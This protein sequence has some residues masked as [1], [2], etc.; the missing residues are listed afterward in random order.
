M[1]AD[2]WTIMQKEWREYFARSGSRGRGLLAAILLMLFGAVLIPLQSG[3]AWL[4]SPVPTFIDG[5]YLPFIVVISVIAD[6][7]AGERERHTLESL[8]ATRLSDR[9]IL[10][11]KIGAAV[12]YALVVAFVS[13]LLGALI[14]D[15]VVLSEGKPLH[16]VFYSGGVVASIV[17]TAL[18]IAVLLAALGCLISLRSPT[19]RQAQQTLSI[20]VTAV[21]FILGFGAQFALAHSGVNLR[22]ALATSNPATLYGSVFAVLLVIDLL[23]VLAALARFQRSRLILS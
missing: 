15:V 22:T 9:A 14:S 16:A 23:L 10:L 18:L 1:A 3:A 6:A 5:A 21:V 2:I 7:F 13:T 11:G 17:G 20:G 12:I 8:L 19:V 4:T